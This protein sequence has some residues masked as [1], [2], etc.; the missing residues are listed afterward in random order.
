MNWRSKEAAMHHCGNKKATVQCATVA[1][2]VKNV[3]LAR[4][5]QQAHFDKAQKAAMQ[6]EFGCWSC[7][8]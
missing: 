1:D 6:R 7:R 4:N 5:G 2:V 8:S 3:M